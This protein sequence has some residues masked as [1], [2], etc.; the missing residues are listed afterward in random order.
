[1]IKLPFSIRSDGKFYNIKI[2]KALWIALVSVYFNTKPTTTLDYFEV[3]TQPDEEMDTLIYRAENGDY[4][5]DDFVF[6]PILQPLYG[7]YI[8]LRAYSTTT[9]QVHGWLGVMLL[10]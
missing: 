4:L 5:K 1:M 9:C 2:P 6:N 3:R 8:Y 10:G 7:D